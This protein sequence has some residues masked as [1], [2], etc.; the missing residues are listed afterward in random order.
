MNRVVVKVGGSLYDWPPLAVRLRQFLD[1]FER[2]R[3][4]VVPGGGPFADAV[5]FVDQTYHLGEE[6]AHWLALQSLRLAADFLRYLLPDWQ[7]AIV[8]MYRFAI[9]DEARPD[10]LPHIWDVTSDSLAARLA[11]V[12]EAQHLIL[13]KSVDPGTDWLTNGVVDEHF[14]SIA[15]IA[16]FRIEVINF[17]SWQPTDLRTTT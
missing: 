12:V 6:A 14:S 4:W 11:R 2:H 9:E 13:L 16:P 7:N 5:R 3:V 17:R 10:H 8:D 1:Q 15:T